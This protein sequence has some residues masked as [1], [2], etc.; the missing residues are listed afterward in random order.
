MLN[1]QLTQIGK[2]QLDL[3]SAAE[4][5]EIIA[6]FGAEISTSMRVVMAALARISFLR[7]VNFIMMR[8]SNSCGRKPVHRQGAFSGSSAKSSRTNCKT[9]V[10]FHVSQ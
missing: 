5:Q 9:S 10:K 1:G 2:T 6:E 3:F 8:K 4:S 7:G